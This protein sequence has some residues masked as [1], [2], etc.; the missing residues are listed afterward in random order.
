MSETTFPNRSINGRRAVPE[1]TISTSH[2]Q[3]ILAQ[4][5]VDDEK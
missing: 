2:E 4:R 5:Y 1:L 3:R